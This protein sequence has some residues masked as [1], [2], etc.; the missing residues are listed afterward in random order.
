MKGMVVAVQGRAVV[1]TLLVVAMAGC[2]TREEIPLASY[3]TAEVLSVRVQDVRPDYATLVFEVRVHNPSTKP[4]LVKN[5]Q[6]GLSSGANSFLSGTP[7]P[8]LSIA[9]AGKETLTLRD[10]V[11]CER[12]LRALDARLDTTIPFTLV[13]RLSLEST[14]GQAMRAPGRASGQLT[15]PPLPQNGETDGS[16][17]PL[18]V[19]YI[20]TPRDVVE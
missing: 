7:I 6:Y 16:N 18:D 8:G 17:R 2:R 20:G 12:L 10:T 3:P 4:A 14:D 13:M 19:I 15:L 1:W 5:L 9:P 11:V